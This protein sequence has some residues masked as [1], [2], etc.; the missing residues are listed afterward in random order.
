MTSPHE[1][2]LREQPAGVKVRGLEWSS[3]P[4]YQVARV[5]GLRLTYSTECVWDEGMFLYCI[6]SGSSINQQFATLE[7]AKAAAQA[8][9]ERRILSALDPAA[10]SR[11]EAAAEAWSR[12]R[13]VSDIA[14]NAATADRLPSST[15]RQVLADI[16]TL[17]ECY[18]ASPV[19]AEPCAAGWRVGR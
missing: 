9:Y 14:H 4:P 12:L 10:L 16:V 8:D 18:G 2:V 15:A 3:E 7:A 13:R 5:P 11:Q 17:S 19:P 6:L 1:Q